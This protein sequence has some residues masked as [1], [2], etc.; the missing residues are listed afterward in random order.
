MV[1]ARLSSVAISRDGGQ[2]WLPMSIPTVLTRIHRVAFSADGTLWLGAREGVY[3]TRDLG[4]TWMWLH[5]LPFGDVDDLSWDAQRKRVMVGS[6][7]SD[8]VFVLDPATLDW[9]YHRTGFPLS[10]IRAANGRL[11]GASL[12]DGVVLEPPPAVGQTPSAGPRL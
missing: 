4:K 2:I 6:R 11:L 1:A 9:S 12:F 10:L 8:Q 7:S 3:Y 5:R